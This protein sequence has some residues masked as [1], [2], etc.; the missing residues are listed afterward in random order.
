MSKNNKFNLIIIPILLAISIAIVF[1]GCVRKQPTQQKNINKHQQ[2]KNQNLAA[3]TTASPQ[4]PKADTSTTTTAKNNE[5]DTGNWKVYRNEEYGFEIKYPENWAEKQS[6]WLQSGEMLPYVM[7]FDLNN[8]S[9]LIIE[10]SNHKYKDNINKLDV[11]LLDNIYIDGIKTY[12]AYREVNL[13]NIYYKYYLKIS[14]NKFLKIY[15]VCKKET[16]ANKMLM[17]TMLNNLYF[18][19]N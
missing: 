10:I 11:N 5:I 17:F 2:Q 4:N 19:R 3:A 18:I 8:Q 1:S 6:H 16:K 7:F 15:F 9:Y 14:N 12:L 13:N